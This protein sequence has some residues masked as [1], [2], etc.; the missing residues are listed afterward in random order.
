[1]C[2]V[3]FASASIFLNSLDNTRTY[4]VRYLHSLIE[5]SIVIYTMLPIVVSYHRYVGIIR[6]VDSESKLEMLE[7]S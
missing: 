4:L 3:F 1:M 2:G 5:K 7:P 6:L